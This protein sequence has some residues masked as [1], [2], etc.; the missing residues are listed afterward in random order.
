MLFF[1]FKQKTAYEM[2]IS[3]WSSD[4]CSSDLSRTAP[5][6]RRLSSPRHGDLPLIRGDRSQADL[7]PVLEL[8]FRLRR[9]HRV[10]GVR[11]LGGVLHRVQPPRPQG[12]LGRGLSEIAT[13]TC[14]QYV[15]QG[16]GTEI[17]RHGGIGEVGESRVVAGSEARAP[18]HMDIAVAPLAL[19][20]AGRHS[21]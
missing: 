17:D 15:F 5:I 3:D 20:T 18:I 13:P 7:Y 11:K 14:G 8:L 10:D 12:G 9:I 4:V 19:R 1:F 21:H 16:Q 6:R 2:R